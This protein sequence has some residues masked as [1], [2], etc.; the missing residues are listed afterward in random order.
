MGADFLYATLPSCDI[1]PERQA[2]LRE[3]V[4]AL[5]PETLPDFMPFPDDIDIEELKTA[6]FA[7]IALLPDMGN[8]SDVS[9]VEVED[10]PCQ[11]Y[12]S[13]GMT[14]GDSPTASYDCM[15]ELRAF[16][17]IVALME[18]WSLEDHSKHWVL[19]TEE[20]LLKLASHAGVAEV[21]IKQH[22]PEMEAVL[23]TNIL[24]QLELALKAL[25]MLQGEVIEAVGGPER[26]VQLQKVMGGKGDGQIP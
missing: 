5:T 23:N 17:A 8:F 3:I 21:A 18:K 20:R 22:F 1:T 9:T 7:N 10:V 25:Q 4:D 6:L 24:E 2:Q 11:Q 16:P 19:P 14:W 26:Y 13:G 12:I 15:D